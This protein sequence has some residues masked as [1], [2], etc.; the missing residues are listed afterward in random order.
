MDKSGRLRG[1]IV[2]DL[3]GRDPTH[4]KMTSEPEGW[5]LGSDR[6]FRAFATYCINSLKM[7]ITKDDNKIIRLMVLTIM[8]ASKKFKNNKLPRTFRRSDIISKTLVKHINNW[9]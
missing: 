2:G 3:I 1:T 9:G 5:I 4:V 6:G 8:Q 7:I